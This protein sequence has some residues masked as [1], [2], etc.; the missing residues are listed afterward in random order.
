MERT[1]NQSNLAGRQVELLNEILTNGE[2]MDLPSRLEMQEDRVVDF[3]IEKHLGKIKVKDTDGKT[4]ENLEKGY[5]LL[6]PVQDDYFYSNLQ[7]MQQAIIQ[8]LKWIRDDE[9]T[10]GLTSRVAHAIIDE[11]RDNSYLRVADAIVAIKCDYGASPEEV[12][13]RYSNKI[14]DKVRKQWLD[15]ALLRVK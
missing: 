14:I 6:T 4:I 15:S 2:I 11:V 5:F 1:N 7:L 8:H 12:A 3:L 13:D 9:L 10:D